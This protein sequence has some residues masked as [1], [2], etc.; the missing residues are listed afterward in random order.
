MN[1]DFE[2]TIKE[3]SVCVEKYLG[4]DSAVE[5]PALIENL[6]VT[7]IYK[8]AFMNNFNLTEIKIPDSVTKIGKCAFAGCE[9]LAK[10]NISNSVVKIEEGIFNDCKNLTEITIPK[11]VIENRC[12]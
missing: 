1:N 12:S 3:N 10:I 7:E 6:P 9:N 8:C 11:S 2:Y 4:E 5:I